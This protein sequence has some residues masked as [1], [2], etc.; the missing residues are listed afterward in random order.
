[1]IK[2]FPSHSIQ[3]VLGS[4]YIEVLQAIVILFFALRAHRKNGTPNV[5]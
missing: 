2:R 5:V 4:V 3:P 1:M